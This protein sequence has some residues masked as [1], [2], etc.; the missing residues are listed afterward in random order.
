MYK[1]AIHEGFTLARYMRSPIIGAALGVVLQRWSGIDPATG[2]GIALLFGLV[3]VCERAI[4]E[5]WKTFLREE[6]QGKYF[7]PMQFSLFGVPVQSRL[8]RWGML[9]LCLVAIV[10][11]VQGVERAQRAAF[12]MPHLLVAV[13]VGSIGGWLTAIGG[14]WKDA[15]K[16]GFE[17]L[18]FFR[19]PLMTAFFALVVSALTDRYLFI[20]MAA[21]GYERAA[22][23]TYKTFFFPDKPR[24]KFAGKPVLFPDMLQ[25]RAPFRFLY[26]GIWAVV[27]VALGQALFARHDGRAPEALTNSVPARAS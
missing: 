23:E 21:V 10:L 22:V 7:I 20:A 13:L 17:P 1:D 18:K 14:A 16:E 9:L 12:D 8:A 26:A 24:G 19:S 25:R 3:Y 27:L 2:R 5:L 4:V 15:P 11:A 6:D